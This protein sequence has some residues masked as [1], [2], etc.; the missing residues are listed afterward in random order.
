LRKAGPGL[1]ANPAPLTGSGVGY[2]LGIAEEV[3]AGGQASAFFTDKLEVFHL[4]FAIMLLVG[5]MLH[6]TIGAFHTRSLG[7]AQVPGFFRHGPA[8]LTDISFLFHG[9]LLVYTSGY[10]KSNLAK[11]DVNSFNDILFKG[12]YRQV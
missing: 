1:E 7:I 11:G 2:V 10:T 5:S 9:F 8:G 3:L 6:A 12:L 4:P